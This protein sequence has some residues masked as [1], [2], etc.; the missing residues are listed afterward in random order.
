M[1]TGFGNKTI[2]KKPKTLN[3]RL[4]KRIDYYFND[5]NTDLWN[6]KSN[7]LSAAR[8]VLKYKRLSY[9]LE[10]ENNNPRW[11]EGDL[12]SKTKIL[13]KDLKEN[14]GIPQEV[15]NLDCDIADAINTYH[16]NIE[17]AW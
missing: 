1:F 7:V 2:E 11:C 17:S 16:K 6:Q 9:L 13:I 5:S 8:D 3:E 14:I 15:I 12:S 10:A 4:I